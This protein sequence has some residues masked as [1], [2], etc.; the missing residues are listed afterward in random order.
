MERNSEDNRTLQY[1][2]SRDFR[3]HHE[4]GTGSAPAKI[5]VAIIFAIA[6]LPGL[7]IGIRSSFAADN[8]SID[9][10]DRVVLHGNVNPKARPEFDVGTSDP[11][12]PMK[13]MTLLLK[14]ASEKQAELDRL[15]AEQQD[16]SSQ[17]FTAG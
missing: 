3:R 17:T 2:G 9:E 12:L 7:S 11:L 16:P 13:R 15:L 1:A 14:I 5:I 8:A 4:G 10:N 6:S